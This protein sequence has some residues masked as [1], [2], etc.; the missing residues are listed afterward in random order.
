MNKRR[1][2]YESTFIVNATLEDPQIEQVIEKVKEQLAK[3]NADLKDLYRWGRK[4]F[5]FPIKKKNNGYYVVMEFEADTDAVSKLDRFFHIEE[6]ILRS[7]ILKLDKHALKSRI[8][9]SDLAK[10]NLGEPGMVSEPDVA[11]LA[12]DVEPE[13]KQS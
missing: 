13:E 9:V 4:R 3:M 12:A 2:L 6:N 5:A 10:Q 1:T 11:P 8:K 7:L